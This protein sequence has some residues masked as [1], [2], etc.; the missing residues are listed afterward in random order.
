MADQL[1]VLADQRPFLW[2]IISNDM[3]LVMGIQVILVLKFFCIIY[4]VCSSV[5]V[6]AMEVLRVK[7]RG[8]LKEMQ[9]GGGRKISKKLSEAL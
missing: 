6:C 7:K 2:L 4:N 8:G 1:N 3:G 5:Y 9:R